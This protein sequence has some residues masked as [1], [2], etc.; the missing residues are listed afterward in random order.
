MNRYGNTTGFMFFKG[1]EA[2]KIVQGRLKP[3]ELNA[4]TFWKP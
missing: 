1:S 4:A 3:I 2:A